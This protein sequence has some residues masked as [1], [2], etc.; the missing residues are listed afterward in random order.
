MRL[1]SLFLLLWSLVILASQGH[2]EDAPKPSFPCDK[3]KTLDEKTI[4]SDARL[5]ELNRIHAAAY[6][7]AKRKNAGEAT[8]EARMRLE[9]R[10]LCGNDRV[11][12]FDSM[13][14]AEGIAMPVWA[15]AYRKELVHPVN[16]W[17]SL[18]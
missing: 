1:A 5:A 15:D 16:C 7:V 8:K 9:E 4:C 18:T 11:C 6:L 17:S 2:G 10:S 3:A 13:S 12:L 14:S